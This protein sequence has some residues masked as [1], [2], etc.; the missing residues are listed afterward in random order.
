MKIA[1]LRS[2]FKKL[3]AFGKLLEERNS[4]IAVFIRNIFKRITND[5][6]ENRYGDL[7]YDGANYIAFRMQTF[8]NESSREHRYEQ[9]SWYTLGFI[10]GF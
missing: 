9:R 10:V 5:D 2:G 3:N 8:M 1:E 7:S 4:D 6:I